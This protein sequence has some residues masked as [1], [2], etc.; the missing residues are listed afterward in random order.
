LIESREQ[1]FG[2]RDQLVIVIDLD[3]LEDVVHAEVIVTH[4]AH[5]IGEIGALAGEALEN[6]DE[7]RRGIVEGVVEFGFVS[8]G[9]GLVSES[10]FAE[11]GKTVV[12]FEIDTLEIVKLGGESENSLRQRRADF[13][14]LR[15]GVFIELAEIGG[16]YA[17]LIQFDFDKFREAGFENFAVGN[18]RVT[19]RGFRRRRS[20]GRHGWH[21]A[22]DG[23]Q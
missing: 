22:E 6:I 12:N 10:F 17:L 19:R 9:A 13:E 2:F 15:V 7:L 16:S 8:F 11:I 14:R 5:Q 4:G 1:A 23:E 3:G 18:R 21:S 20:A